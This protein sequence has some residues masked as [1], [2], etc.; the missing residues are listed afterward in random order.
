VSDP[1][2]VMLC[3]QDLNGGGGSERQAIEVARA[4]DRRRFAP[5]VGCFRLGPDVLKQLKDCGIPVELWRLRSLLSPHGVKVAW[6]IFRYLR[7]EKIA[8]IHAF[9]FPAG[10]IVLPI[11]R[12]AGVPAVLAS[13]RGDRL[14]TAPGAIRQ[15]WQAWADTK[16]D[17]IVINSEQLSQQLTGDWH[18][19]ASKI[20]QC[21]NGI[22]AARFQVNRGLAG[23]RPPALAGASLVI[24]CIALWRPEKDLLCL[25]DAF[26]QVRSPQGGLKL[27]LIGAGELESAMR[28]RVR[29]LSLGDDVILQPFI[30]D[31]APWH[32]AIDIFVLPSKSEAMSNSLMEAMA[33]G[34]AVVVSAIGGNVELVTPDENGLLFTAGDA[35]ALADCL[36]CLISDPALRA[37]L[38]EAA[39][40]LMRERYSIPAM[41]QRMEAIYDEF[42]HGAGAQARARV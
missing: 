11:A 6:D 17:A 2:P 27:I 19:P 22:N 13:Q 25:I 39:A 10:V 29:E 24:G 1:I 8:L 16:V 40:R 4:L 15:R 36:R 3:C 35:S 28:A 34:A 31:V 41:A 18:I 14:L 20:R 33:S 9:D 12:Y 7:R 30:S 32:A 5:R 42:L 21:P 23:R 26:A 38:G 37:R